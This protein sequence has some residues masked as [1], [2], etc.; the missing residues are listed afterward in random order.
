MSEL[1]GWNVDELRK[2]LASHRPDVGGGTAVLVGASLGASLMAMAAAVT[3]KK[4]DPP[5]LAG[6][7]NVVVEAGERL[8]ALAEADG[9]SYG[10]VVE[11]QRLPAEDP[12]RSARVQE[13]LEHAVRVP[14]DAASTCRDLL[15]ICERMLEMCRPVVHTDLANAALLLGVGVRGS[16]F[17]V[18]QNCGSLADPAEWRKR[19]DDLQA[20]S[21]EIVQRIVG[22]VDRAV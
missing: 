4:A 5:G 19:A 6:F 9:K 16:L 21:Q 8:L 18:R 1:A 17:N 22:K 2:A 12:S 11:A 13:A 7:R 15:G 10:A 14:L 20:S 3:L